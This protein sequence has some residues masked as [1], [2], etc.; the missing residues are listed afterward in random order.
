[1]YFIPGLSIR[2]V[3]IGTFVDGPEAVFLVVLETSWKR[4]GNEQG[5]SLIMTVPYT[6]CLARSQLV[7]STTKNTASELRVRVPDGCGEVVLVVHPLKM[8]TSSVGNDR[9]DL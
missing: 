5:T 3:E 2:Q 4:A 1:M 9:T 6:S 8:L 7:S